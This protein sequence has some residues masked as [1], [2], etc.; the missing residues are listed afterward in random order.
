MKFRSL[1]TNLFLIAVAMASGALWYRSERVPD[2]ISF[3]KGGAYF[4]FT[5]SPHRVAATFARKAT[6]KTSWEWTIDGG[7]SPVPRPTFLQSHHFSTS[8]DLGYTAEK[9]TDLGALK[10]ETG[11][12]KPVEERR[13]Y[14]G[15]RIFIDLGGTVG[16]WTIDVSLSA[17]GWIAIVL[18]I[19]RIVFWRWRK[20]RRRGNAFEVLPSSKKMT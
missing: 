10:F 16:Y 14:K 13:D 2:E 17:I 4:E 15:P 11:S 18:L 6:W 3:T 20:R 7:R 5:L 1:I 9:F 12:I 8:A 19:F